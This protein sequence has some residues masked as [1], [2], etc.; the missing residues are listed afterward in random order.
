[1]N[2]E[3]PVYMRPHEPDPFPHVDVHMRSTW[4]THRSLETARWPSGPKA[5][6]RLCDCN[7][8]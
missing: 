3:P 8:F 2:F 7:L 5:E 4:N 1:L 6:I